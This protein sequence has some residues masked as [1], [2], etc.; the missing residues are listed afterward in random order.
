MNKSKTKIKKNIKVSD[1]YLIKPDIPIFELV[2]LYPDIVEFLVDEYEFYCFNC[3]LAEYETLEEGATSHG[4]IGEDF[5]EM[6][7]RINEFI[8]SSKEDSDS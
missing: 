4:I 1:S 8:L 7:M 2:E 3:V 5:A 6:M